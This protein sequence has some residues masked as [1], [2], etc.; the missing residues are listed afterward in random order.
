MT[1]G[2]LIDVALVILVVIAGISGYRQGALA[3]AMSL[4]GLVI[5]AVAGILVAPRVISGISATQTRLIVGIAVLVALVVVGEIA[6]MVVGRTLR[7]GFGQHRDARSTAWSAWRCR[8]WPWSPQP[9]CWRHR[10]ATR[11]CRRPPAPS[12]SRVC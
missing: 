2:L 6:G 5:G 12:T 3:S 9:G 4:V 8:R 10:S 1:A 11:R 7:E